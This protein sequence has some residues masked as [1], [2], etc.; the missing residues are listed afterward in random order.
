MLFRA[1]LEGRPFTLSVRAE[2]VTASLDTH[3]VVASDAGGRLYSVYRE[4]HTYRR[5]LNGRVLH[6][7]QDDQGRHW[8]WLD[9]SDADRLVHEAAALFERAA[10]LGTREGWSDLAGAGSEDFDSLRR[11]AQFTADLARRDAE[12]FAAMYRP[13]GILPPDHYLSLVLQLT[14]GCSFNT[15]TFC[16]LYHEPY[17]VKT[18]GEF[19]SHVADVCA[20]LGPS[21]GLRRRAVFLGAANALAVPMARL[22]PALDV[23]Q[24]RLA[25]QGGIA[26][27]V[28][29]FTGTRKRAEDYRELGARGL[30]RVYIGLESGHDPLLAF[31]RK[32]ATCG[33]A[34]ETA[35]AVKAAGLQLAVIVML[36]LG[37]DRFSDG[38]GRDTARALTE[39]GL[40]RGDLLY[41]SDLVEVPATA[42]PRLTGSEGIQPL[43]PEARATQRDAILA[44]I[45][46]AR[47][48]PQVARYDVREFVY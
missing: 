1:T 40:G 8:E 13:V 14:D 37:G 43:S 41:F 21:L 11:A 17:R 34:L 47:P 7:F 32:P 42:Y 30:R 25:P 45:R 24:H 38:H 10:D 27:F 26:A 12:R 28:D 18:P 33:E 9:G 16:D 3:Y 35:R 5:G 46:F 15:C 19:A 31:V 36:G 23:V 48:G 4:G 6:K 29:G 22:V 2:S 44:G 39:M 20:W